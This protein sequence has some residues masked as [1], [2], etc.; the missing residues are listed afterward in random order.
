MDWDGRR[1][2]M[3]EPCDEDDPESE[4]G[5]LSGWRRRQNNEGVQLL[6]IHYNGW[7]H[8]WDEWI[9]SDSERIRPFRTR[10][11]HP[12]IAPYISP[13]PQSVFNE[14]P[15]TFIQND[16]EEADRAALLPELSRVVAAVS[17]VL[18]QAAGITQSPG[19]NT[20]INNLPWFERGSNNGMAEDDDS[21]SEEE[22]SLPPNGY[23]N[24]YDSDEVSPATMPEPRRPVG[25]T[26]SKQRSLTRR[27]L[28][29]LAP[30][31]DRLG[32]TLT[33]AAPHVASLAS[34]LP[35]TDSANNEQEQ[36]SNTENHESSGSI[37]GLFSL[38]SRSRRNVTAETTGNNV[39]ERVN[40]DH[41]DY[42]SGLVNTFRGEVRGGPRTRQ[43]D[44]PGLL[45]AYLAAA[46]MGS[47]SNDENEN[48][49]EGGNGLQGLGRLFRDRPAGG[50]GNGID[51]HI[52]A[53][54][55]TPGVTGGAF[56]LGGTTLAD[57]TNPSPAGLT[58]RGLFSRRAPGLL[59]MT[60][61]SSQQVEDDLGLFSDLY[62][63]NPSPVNP[64]ATLRPGGFS[65]DNYGRGDEN[66]GGSADDI[67]SS[68]Y[69][70]SR[71]STFGLSHT[72]SLTITPLR[73]NNNN[74]QSSRAGRRS[75]WSS[76]PSP[77]RDRSASPSR[78]DSSA[79]G[80]FFRRLGRRSNH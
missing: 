41:M 16:D 5:E 75:S 23:G 21:P 37:S 74:S 73:L 55:T 53:I 60:T 2:L 47:T 13:T 1:R 50:G 26:R 39:N 24:S 46:S 9:R 20:N 49:G 19:I 30:L 34:T 59:S 3:L 69:A 52:H 29:L 56:G 79:F 6:L 57:L 25:S 22:Y 44:G 58:S 77:P 68:R 33:D 78:R 67:I 40:P 31:L 62:T 7:P 45:G 70:A 18:A 65:F 28:E 8:R 27:Q 15:S 61:A 42:A 35:Q 71:A 38:L 76:T 14:A 10:T 4:G 17:D 66:G 64:T 80:R 54:V 48:N 72:D 12:S 11:R 36:D 43:D 51:I 63:E 32:R